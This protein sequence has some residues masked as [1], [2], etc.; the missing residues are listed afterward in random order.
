[1][2]AYPVFVSWAHARPQPEV[3]DYDPT[4]KQR[5]FITDLLR[6]LRD[7]TDFDGVPYF[8]DIQLRNGDD[9]PEE[10]LQALAV[11]QVFVPMY[12]LRYFTQP[13]RGHEW[14]AL[15]YRMAA[16]RRDPEISGQLGSVPIVP[17]RWHP[18]PNSRLH[19]V[20]RPYHS[21]GDELGD[22][23]EAYYRHG[24]VGLMTDPE[25]ATQYQSLFY[26]LACRIRDVSESTR[27]APREPDQIR[28][29]PPAFG[30]AQ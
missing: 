15:E 5:E 29:L 6:L 9:V 17:I 12:S 4:G 13:W 18:T 14:S 1:M 30:G 11:F 8:A 19:L 23:R 16:Q 26:R 10:I 7:I 25:Y 27:F 22:V 24:V 20:A 3:P 2:S 21:S 28:S